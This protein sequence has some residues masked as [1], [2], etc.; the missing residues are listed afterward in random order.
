MKD[1][2]KQLGLVPKPLKETVKE[3]NLVPIPGRF[4]CVPVKEAF[5]RKKATSKL[6]LP[7][8]SDK[9][10]MDAGDIFF[11]HPNQMQVVAVGPPFKSVEGG[12]QEQLVKVGDII[13]YRPK[14]NGFIGLI[15]QGHTFLELVT[16]DIIAVINN[17]Q[18]FDKI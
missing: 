17:D 10:K 11:D 9:T 1:K 2:V 14:P 4:F 8:A 7:N 15:F 5:I 16:N 6:I 18:T 13:A 3:L 12:I